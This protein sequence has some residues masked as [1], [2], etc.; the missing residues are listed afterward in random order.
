LTFAP[1]PWHDSD[2]GG[3]AT[4]S[5]SRCKARP[6][7]STESVRLERDSLTGGDWRHRGLAQE[8][9]TPDDLGETPRPRS[10]FAKTHY[11]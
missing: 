11:K 1:R 9:L 10:G 5:N 4:D 6:V 3:S 8:T 7:H 2:E